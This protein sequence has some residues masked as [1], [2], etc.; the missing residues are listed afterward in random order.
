MI[1]QPESCHLVEIV[2]CCGFDQ[3][4]QGS[5]RRGGIVGYVPSRAAQGIEDALPLQC[6]KG[7][8]YGVGIDP[9]RQCD[10]P[11][12]KQLFARSELTRHDPHADLL[13]DLRTN[14][15]AFVKCP[16]QLHHLFCITLL[17][18]SYTISKTLSRENGQKSRS[19]GSDR[20]FCYSWDALIPWVIQEF[21]EVF[22]FLMIRMTA[23]AAAP[24]TITVTRMIAMIAPVPRPSVF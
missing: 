16:F 17:I 4:S 23:V 7:F 19:E 5:A 9:R 15:T 6:F 3:R 12:R 10:L 18:Q 20:L 11:Y 8:L 2:G 13:C 24:H 21:F 22:F 14:R 1:R